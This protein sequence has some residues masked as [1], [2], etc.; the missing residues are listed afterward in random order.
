MLIIIDNV[1]EPNSLNKEDILFPN[2][3]SASYNILN[4]DAIF[5]LLLEKILNYMLRD[6]AIYGIQRR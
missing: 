6:S 3:P 2:D 5:Y 4:S 1:N